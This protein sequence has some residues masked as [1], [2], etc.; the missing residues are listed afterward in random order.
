VGQTGMQLVDGFDIF[1]YHFHRSIERFWTVDDVDG[2]SCILVFILFFCL[3]K[4]LST[5][6]CFVLRSPPGLGLQSGVLIWF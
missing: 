1:L 3:Y 6:L 4:V 5:L 2:F